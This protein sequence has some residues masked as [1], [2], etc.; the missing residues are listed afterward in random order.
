MVVSGMLI[1][2]DVENLGLLRKLKRL[3]TDTLE[4][5]DHNLMPE[6]S[7]QVAKTNATKE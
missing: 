7:R 4:A 2:A 3:G 6:C 1:A 5:I